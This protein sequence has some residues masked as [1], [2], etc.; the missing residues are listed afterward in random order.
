M[1]KL[2]FVTL[3]LFAAVSA[4]AGN[5]TDGLYFAQDDAFGR[6]GWKSNV[7]LE[8]RNGRIRSAVWN[9]TK[10]NGGMDKISASEAGRYP[11][12]QQGGARDDW[13]I[14]AKRVQNHLLKTQDPTQISYSDAEGHT[15]AISGA[16]IHVR[17][18]FILAQKALAAGPVD[19]GPYRDG[20]FQA[21]E[22]VF[23]QQSG[24]KSFAQFTVV[25]GTVVQVNWNGFH[26]D[27]GESKKIVSQNGEYGMMA[28]GG[29]QAEWHVQAN[30]VEEYYLRTGGR[31][32]RFPD[33]YHTDAISGATIG[34]KPLYAL[35]EQAL[36]RR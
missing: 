21:E 3:V 8:V 24:W 15:D 7:T 25:N 22:A 31:P 28:N 30:N 34:V 4:F 33:N 35:A 10:I 2:I 6:T 29:A 23:S 9:G 20:Y 11:M 17:E 1:K 19:R 36:R 27:G 14:Q 5:W 26:K 32:P 12:V 16:T 18:F 13:H